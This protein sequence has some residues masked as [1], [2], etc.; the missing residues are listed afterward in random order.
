MTAALSE[1]TQ[2]QGRLVVLT[3]ELSRP[4][5]GGRRRLHRLQE[6]AGRA[7]WGNAKSKVPANYALRLDLPSRLNATVKHVGIYPS[8]QPWSDKTPQVGVSS[9]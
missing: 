4:A 6:Q 8:L 2:S 3:V 5:S 7:L 1:T 9:I